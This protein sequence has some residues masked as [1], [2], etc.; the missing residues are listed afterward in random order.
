MYGNFIQEKLMPRR[1]KAV[2]VYRF[3]NIMSNGAIT[4]SDYVPQY[5]SEAPVQINNFV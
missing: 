1:E 5:T 2:Q 4:V 3:Q